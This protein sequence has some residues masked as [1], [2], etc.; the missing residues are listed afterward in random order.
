MAAL[1]I[2][3]LVG[4]TKAIWN[5]EIKSFTDELNTKK[6]K[7]GTDYTIEYQEANGQQ[8]EYTAIAN[9]F[10]NPT[11]PI[12]IDIIVTGGT[13]ATIACITATNRAP[14]KVPQIMVFFATAGEDGS[15]FT[16]LGKNVTGISNQ[17]IT[18]VK[19][20]LDHMNKYVPPLLVPP[21]TPFTV[22][23]VIGNANAYNV[24]DEMAAVVAQAPGGLTAKKSTTSLKTAADIPTVIQSVVSQGAQ[25]LYVCTDPLITSNADILNNAALAAGLPTMHAFKK[26]LGKSKD[27]RLL[28]WEPGELRDMFSQCADLVYNWRTKGGGALPKSTTPKGPPK[29]QP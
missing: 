29:S 28:Y 19:D 5:D 13:D 15:Y 26:N 27:N 3:F 11:R 10:A 16:A 14:Q 24:Q 17:Q 21:N 7:E 22:F 20:R 9:D 18:H 1:S 25:A 23:G 2:G 12:G 4:T 8:D 6:W